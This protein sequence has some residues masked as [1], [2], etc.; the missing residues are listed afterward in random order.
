M[1]IKCTVI[2]LMS[3]EDIPWQIEMI[4]KTRVFITSRI[5]YSYSAISND[6]PWSVSLDAAPSGTS[7]YSSGEF[8]MKRVAG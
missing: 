4:Q 2:A 5:S 7:P 1:R 8:L 6:L 3:I